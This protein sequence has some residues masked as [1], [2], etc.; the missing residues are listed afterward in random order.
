MGKLF[1]KKEEVDSDEEKIYNKKFREELAKLKKEYGNLEA[2]ESEAEITIKK[3]AVTSESESSDD[4]QFTVYSEDERQDVM[5][6]HK[7]NLHRKMSYLG[8]DTRPKKK[9]EPEEQPLELPLEE[10]A[11]EEQE[12]QQEEEPEEP[13][14]NLIIF[15][16]NGDQF[17]VTM[18][19]DAPVYDLKIEC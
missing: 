18:P 9:E 14:V 2:S 16:S 13:K 5:P 10:E 8:Y 6:N 15:L 12:E 3:K 4:S 1:G 11:E 19:Y 7:Y 17:N